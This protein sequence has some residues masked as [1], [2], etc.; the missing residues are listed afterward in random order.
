MLYT[1]V[2][3]TRSEIHTTHINAL[4]GHNVEI[5]SVKPEGTYSNHWACRGL[6]YLRFLKHNIQKLL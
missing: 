5:L 2:I 4:C 3:V 6:I 1:E